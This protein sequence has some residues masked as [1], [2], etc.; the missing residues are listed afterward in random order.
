MHCSVFHPLRLA[1]LREGSSRLSMVLIPLEVSLT[2]VMSS[3]VADLCCVCWRWALTAFS[4]VSL[5]ISD[6]AATPPPS[7]SF[8]C[9]TMV[10]SSIAQPWRCRRGGIGE[11]TCAFLAVCSTRQSRLLRQATRSLMQGP[12]EIS[13]GIQIIS[14]VP[15]SRT[16]EHGPHMREP[17]AAQQKQ[18]RRAQCG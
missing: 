2:F 5:R 14:T 11:V 9:R 16:V 12:R 6:W 13:G 7:F 17:S 8:F 3:S 1:H 10:P 4:V 15:S 18:H